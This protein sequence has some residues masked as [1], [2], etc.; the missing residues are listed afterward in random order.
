MNG[1]WLLRWKSAGIYVSYST[2]KS[3]MLQKVIAGKIFYTLPRMY[4]A[5]PLLS[6]CMA[7]FC[8]ST[9]WKWSTRRMACWLK[10]SEDVLIEHTPFQTAVWDPICPKHFRRRFLGCVEAKLWSQSLTFEAIIES[11]T[12]RTSLN[13]STL[14]NWPHTEFRW[15]FA[16]CFPAFVQ[17]QQIFT[18]CPW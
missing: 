9:L 2:S 12:R 14:T 17:I 13:S 7:S 18:K 10:T 5:R 1:F 11:W 4:D 3:K 16:N 8:T 15:E 6:S